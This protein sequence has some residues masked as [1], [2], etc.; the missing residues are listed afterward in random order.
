MDKLLNYVAHSNFLQSLASNTVINLLP[1]SITHNLS[2][3]IL[4]KKIIYT[5]SID[6]IKSDYIEY[7]VFTGSSIKHAAR[8][9]KKFKLFSTKLYGL[10]FLVVFLKIFIK[11]LKMKIL[12]AIIIA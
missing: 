4:I 2:K 10:D 7:G 1:I 12:L 5:L 6:D 3:Y 9:Y 11:N 8:C